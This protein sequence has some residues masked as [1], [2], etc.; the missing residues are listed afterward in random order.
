MLAGCD[1][2]K[3]DGPVEDIPKKS[4]VL[5]TSKDSAAEFFKNKAQPAPGKK[6]R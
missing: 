3:T 1:N 4:P 5:T 2:S 6:T